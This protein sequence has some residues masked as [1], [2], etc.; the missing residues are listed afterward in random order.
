MSG[1]QFML[2]CDHLSDDRTTN[3]ITHASQNEKKSRGAENE[4]MW[5]AGGFGVNEI[6]SKKRELKMNECDKWFE[7]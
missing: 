6:R 5:R 7:E 1:M 2:R 3:G 4:E